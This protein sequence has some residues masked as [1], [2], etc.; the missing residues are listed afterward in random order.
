MI[1]I[2]RIALPARMLPHPRVSNLLPVV[3]KGLTMCHPALPPR[4]AKTRS[5]QR[6]APLLQPRTVVAE[7]Y[8][9]GGDDA[10]LVPRYVNISQ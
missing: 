10:L 4:A 7:W 3:R 5:Q 2:K 9:A 8:A 6:R 1:A